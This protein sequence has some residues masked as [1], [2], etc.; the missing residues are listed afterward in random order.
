MFTRVSIG[1][2]VVAALL[3]WCLPGAPA[4]A[5]ADHA[6]AAHESAAE[7]E[8][9][10]DAGHGGGHG[11]GG[12]G[13]VNPLSFKADLAIWTAVIFL[14][15]LAVLW[16]FAWGPIAQGLDKR[17]QGIADQIAQAE[18]SNEE[19]RRLLEEYQQKLAASEDEVRRIVE[20]GRRDGEQVGRDIVQK[21]RAEAEAE[22]KRSL[23]E[24]EAATAGALKELAERGAELAVTL[25]GKIVRA[26]LKPADHI[27]L[28][29][30]AVKRFRRQKTGANGDPPTS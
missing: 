1:L 27:Q 15:L 17:E 23:R 25:A 29:E 8:S 3:G 10:H 22:R 20:Q 16:K 26:E 28:I 12:G 30:D 9:S 24:I 2:V 11:E 19:A 5:A 7:S 4:M 21:A 13:G 18:K 6:G 14:L